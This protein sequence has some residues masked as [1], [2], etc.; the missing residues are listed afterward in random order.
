MKTTNETMGDRC[1][2]CCRAASAP[3]RRTDAAGNVIEGCVAKAH[4]AHADAWH[5]R[6]SAVWQR[7]DYDAHVRTILG[8]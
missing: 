6:P 8:E 5:M 1:N 3:Y 7:A 2:T 4:D